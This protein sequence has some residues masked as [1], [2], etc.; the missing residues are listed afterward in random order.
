MKKL[1]KLLFR[2]EGRIKLLGLVHKHA[3]FN[4]AVMSD[5]RGSRLS[6]TYHVIVNFPY[7]RDTLVT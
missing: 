5:G 3:N 6:R 4:I 7:T 2:P 1:I